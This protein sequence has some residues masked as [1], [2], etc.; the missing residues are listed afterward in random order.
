M[1]EKQI[2]KSTPEEETF[3]LKDTLEQS[4][5]KVS[6]IS[7]TSLKAAKN[8]TIQL[9]ETIS[10]E[11]KSA[12]GVE[13]NGKYE[14]SVSFEQKPL[15]ESLLRHGH[16]VGKSDETFKAEEIISESSKFD[17]A[18]VSKE[19]SNLCKVKMNERQ[20]GQK[21][22]ALS[23]DLLEVDSIEMK[24]PKTG[25]N[26]SKK[27]K[28]VKNTKVIGQSLCEAHA[29][30]V[31]LGMLLP[32]EKADEQIVPDHHKKPVTLVGI[33]V[34]FNTDSKTAGSFIGEKIEHLT[35]VV[36]DVSK[37]RMEAVIKNPLSIVMSQEFSEN[38]L[39][40]KNI[41]Q[42]ETEAKCSKEIGMQL[43]RAIGHVSEIGQSDEPCVT[44]IYKTELPKAEG[45]LV[46][47]DFPSFP[48][49]IQLT[50][51]MGYLSACEESTPISSTGFSEE[52]V[53]EIR[54]TLT[55]LTT[56]VE[57]LS[58][59]VGLH[60]Q[61][62]NTQHLGKV[63]TLETVA[64]EKRSI[65]STDNL[66]LRNPTEVVIF[67]ETK[68]TD[69]LEEKISEEI[70]LPLRQVTSTLKEK[71][72]HAPKTMAYSPNTEE[73]IYVGFESD[74]VKNI[75]G[76]KTSSDMNIQPIRKSHTVGILEKSSEKV[77]DLL[78]TYEAEQ[79]AFSAALEGDAFGKVSFKSTEMWD[80][81]QSDKT[82][83]IA[84]KQAESL[85]AD[86]VLDKSQIGQKAL[87][88]GNIICFA[89]TELKTQT[90]EH[91]EQSTEGK[92]LS[93]ITCKAQLE[94]AKSVEKS[95]GIFVPL[96]LAEVTSHETPKCH[97]IT[98]HSQ[99]LKKGMK[100]AV[101]QAKSTLSDQ[102]FNLESL[103][104]PSS[105]LGTQSTE[106]TVK[107]TFKFV[108]KELG[109]DIEVLGTEPFQQTALRKLTPKTS[110]I[111]TE[112]K[113]RVISTP[114]L[115]AENL[116]GEELQDWKE[117]SSTY[118]TAAETE[119]GQ[120]S[121]AK[122]KENQVGFIEPMICS[123][124]P[125]ITDQ[126]EPTQANKILEVDKGF[127]QSIFSSNL[128]GSHTGLEHTDQW[129]NDWKEESVVPSQTM[130]EKH[131]RAQSNERLVGQN[132]DTF[133]TNTI[134][135]SE[136]VNEKMVAP[137]ECVPIQRNI[138]L[139]ESVTTE[140]YLKQP[141]FEEAHLVEINVESRNTASNIEHI[142]GLDCEEEET[143]EYNLKQKELESEQTG[144][145]SIEIKS[146]FHKPISN[147]KQFGLIQE[148]TT[149]FPL[150]TASVKSI[151][152]TTIINQEKTQKF[153]A[154]KVSRALGMSNVSQQT[155]KLV[156]TELTE[157]VL[158]PQKVVSKA[159]N[160]AKSNERT[161]GIDFEGTLADEFKHIDLD[162]D[163]EGKIQYV[164]SLSAK[165]CSNVNIEGYSPQSEETNILLT[166]SESH[167]KALEDKEGVYYV[168]ANLIGKEMG[169][170]P[171]E[172]NAETVDD[173]TYPTET[174]S[175]GKEPF[176]RFTSHSRSKQMGTKLKEECSQVLEMFSSP[177]ETPLVSRT[178]HYNERPATVSAHLMGT[179]EAEEL[180]KKFSVDFPG[181]SS[182]T[183]S[184]ARPLSTERPKIQSHQMVL[185]YL[186]EVAVARTGTAQAIK[187]LSV[188]PVR[189]KSSKEKV[190][191]Q[192]ILQGN[193]I[194]DEE[195]KMLSED[196]TPSKVPK[197][198][199]ISAETKNKIGR[200]GR[201]MGLDA[202]EE[203]SVDL[204]LEA[205]KPEISKVDIVKATGN[206]RASRM[207][208]NYGWSDREEIVLPIEKSEIKS[209]VPCYKSTSSNVQLAERKSKLMFSNNQQELPAGFETS[210]L[211]LEELSISKYKTDSRKRASSKSREQ[212]YSMLIERVD[213]RTEY[214]PGTEEAKILTSESKRA[215]APFNSVLI[216][217][218][219]NSENL[220]EQPGLEPFTG[221]AKISN[222][223]EGVTM[224][225]FRNSKPLGVSIH[226]TIYIS[227]CF[228]DLEFGFEDF[229]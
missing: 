101:P 117:I 174:V 88:Q 218:G 28:A 7:T 96:S 194:Q 220:K 62:E 160:R 135:K 33:N 172:F 86:F 153:K 95:M 192:S 23:T 42:S 180:A 5:S 120:I 215:R 68:A 209:E 229:L 55:D 39:L 154:L 166:H 114:L 91:S 45:D 216:G 102:Y 90:L 52:Q 161:M 51:S 151:T 204:K 139:P 147:D 186:P 123:S 30:Q 222:T 165:A 155:Q 38:E 141:K 87:K 85:K 15:S 4:N 47:V 84:A 8:E 170:K 19:M 83:D 191:L 146:S 134:F 116:A 195:L 171:E 80:N 138:T 126:I 152:P 175:E 205:I 159:K 227:S 75:L 158:K 112:V 202:S 79:Q 20:E 57:L 143:K 17:S 50:K 82:E 219:Q 113:E 60:Q 43:N 115:S 206:R 81:K 183:V 188:S 110:T 13:N 167:E 163:Q 213:N 34:G 31:E 132:M 71:A 93:S 140:V 41:K 144:L 181:L 168:S 128:V 48:N 56:N 136:T 49:K 225:A 137:G 40:P 35:P 207:S 217:F 111:K 130:I 65:L 25:T 107:E 14:A 26:V 72:V 27:N 44:N 142:A 106:E 187:S 196:M 199:R 177:N 157:E 208:K 198:S 121:F 12:E 92:V 224:K 189:I 133:Q 122:N 11:Q 100:H 9:G 145:P 103:A 22:Q 221:Q 61:L 108:E 129:K 24:S 201:S 197:V 210:P 64:L 179:Q 185:N 105:E 69:T 78:E 58:K 89:P 3:K 73:A 182:P 203:T 226:Y 21:I 148:E 178:K 109:S 104:L 2:G 6:R 190:R 37:S 10:T 32:E 1:Q 36:Q 164:S 156:N 125:L 63:K 97:V 16:Q 59:E 176:N 150:S 29:V 193:D 173:L 76:T 94:Q 223:T 18:E 46:T 53:P 66:A 212:G 119:E 149:A 127:K 124:Q 99:L 162:M 200:T 118:G 74:T 98:K 70:N 211:E 169:Q 131:K 77:P 184:Q 228:L 54:E 67:Q 214:L